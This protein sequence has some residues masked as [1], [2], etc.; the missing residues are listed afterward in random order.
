MP[1]PHTSDDDSLSTPFVAAG[2]GA[3]GAPADDAALSLC[4]MSTVLSYGALLSLVYGSLLTI[5]VPTEMGA[6]K[7]KNALIFPLFSPCSL[8][9]STSHPFHLYLYPLA[10]LSP[11]F[12]TLEAPMID[13][14]HARPPSCEGSSF[15]I[16]IFDLDHAHPPS[17][18]GRPFPSSSSSLIY[19]ILYI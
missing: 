14:D 17:C 13:L 10:T 1:T 11:L 7:L 9:L 16:F 12:F 3:A 2:A 19:Y 5:V 6:L 4:R 18:M 15:P 8:F